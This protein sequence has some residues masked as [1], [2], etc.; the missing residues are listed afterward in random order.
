M[1][2][3]R[4]YWQDEVDSAI[5]SRE[6]FYEVARESL[7]LYQGNNFFNAEEYSSSL[8]TDTARR[9]NIWWSLVNTLL[10]AYYSRTPKV[11]ARDRDYAGTR[12]STFL[13]L[14]TEKFLQ[15]QLDE[16][17]D[18]HATA[19]K[20]VQQWMLVGEM[21]LWCRV[22]Y[23]RKYDDRSRGKLVLESLHYK[24]FLRPALRDCDPIP[25]KARRAYMDKEKAEALFGTK[26]AADLEY[27]YVSGIE[28]HDKRSERKKYGDEE[29]GGKAE[30]FEIWCDD[31]QK[32]YRV[33][34]GGDFFH[35]SEPPA[36]FR[37]FFPCVD[38]QSS[39]SVD[40]NVPIGD[41][42][43]ARDLILEVERLSSRVQATGQAIRCNFLYDKT[44][45]SQVQQ[46]FEGDLNGLP[47]ENFP[48][49]PGSKGLD[50]ALWFPPNDK[51]IQQLQILLSARSEAMQRL[52]EIIP[53]SDLIRGVTN[54][55]ETATAQQLKSNYSGLRFSLRQKQLIAT[56]AEALDKL[57]DLAPQVFQFEEVFQI[58][59]G[60]ALIAE[61]GQVDP[62]ILQQLYFDIKNKS[63]SIEITADSMVELDE[64]A[65][66]QERTDFLK[67]AGQFLQQL[68]PIMAKYPS[69][70]QPASELLTFVLKSYRAGKE[71]EGTFEIAFQ[72]IAMELQQQKQGQQGQQDPGQMEAQA[73]L[74]VAQINQ[75][76]E[77]QK[78][79]IEM[80][81][82]QVDAETKRLELQVKM[83]QIALDRQKLELEQMKILGEGQIKQ[84]E[85]DTE[86]KKLVA[87]LQKEAMDT[88]Q[89]MIKQEGDLNKELIKG[90]MQNAKDIQVG[91]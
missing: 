22:D 70:T 36:F 84:L 61:T 27:I 18:F 88:E 10:P 23:D 2:Y 28:D 29:E 54:A 89:A 85:F 35:E 71:L 48:S 83:E 87:E 81:K 12:E 32:V 9:I 68:E 79:Q 19:I 76:I 21:C 78:A 40:S 58:A 77:G 16:E 37:G 33:T 65:D 24:D 7:E 80:Q 67:S 47:L 75:Q 66:R 64:R 20:A 15:Y 39:T 51:Y 50:G 55:V 57:S 43:I 42:K 52:Y 49:S 4:E 8:E 13:A 1:K 46:L 91:L 53:A 30:V 6:K 5:K 44:L 34:R 82:M 41:F 63:Y 25:W 69:F 38:L 74:Q 56:L 72:A 14:L 17:L 31:S 26:K 86:N 45:G 11:E 73:K 90:A 60:Q 59:N 62:Q 3:D